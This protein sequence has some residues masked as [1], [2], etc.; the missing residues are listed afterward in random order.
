MSVGDIG[1]LSAQANTPIIF[2]KTC[3]V[4]QQFVQTHNDCPFLTPSTY[5]LIF[6]VFQFFGQVQKFRHKELESSFLLLSKL[7]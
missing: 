3:N 5:F 7:F 4:W 1:R 6:N 2:W